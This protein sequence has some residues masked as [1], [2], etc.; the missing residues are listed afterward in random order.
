LLD[1]SRSLRF[2]HATRLRLVPDLP[3]CPTDPIRFRGLAAL[4]R[5]WL[6]VTRSYELNPLSVVGSE[7]VEDVLFALPRFHAQPPNGSAR[8]HNGLIQGRRRP[9]AA[10]GRTIAPSKDLAAS[11]GAGSPACSARKTALDPC[12]GSQAAAKTAVPPSLAVASCSL[13]FVMVRAREIIRA[14]PDR[15]PVSASNSHGHRSGRLAEWEF[16]T[17]S[18]S[19]I[20]TEPAGTSSTAN[21]GRRCALPSRAAPGLG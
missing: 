20:P 3:K 4:V 1:S 17:T 6:N 21:G 10:C 14:L 15:G 18:M 7:L 5:Y 12:I 16:M 2:G 8:H 11:F 13:M 19:S 9:L